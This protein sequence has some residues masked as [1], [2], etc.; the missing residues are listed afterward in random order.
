MMIDERD[1]ADVTPATDWLLGPVSREEFLRDHRG[2]RHLLLRRRSPGHYRELFSLARFDELLSGS[3]LHA[4]AVRVVRDGRADGGAA[5]LEDLYARYRDGSTLIMPSVHDRWPPLRELCRRLAGEF[6]AEC[7]V[8]AYLTPPRARGFDVHR[9]SHDVFVLQ[10][11]GSKRWRIHQDARQEFDLCEGDLLYLPRGLPHEAASAHGTSLHLSVG[12]HPLTWADVLLAGCEAAV[13]DD[14]AFQEPLPFGFART[15]GGRAATRERV[16]ELTARLGAVLTPDRLAD[17][18]VDMALL[19]EGDRLG[20]HL[21][22]LAGLAG[23]DAGTAVRRRPG[24]RW[25]TRRDAGTL[26]LPFHGKR[27]SLPA[28]HEAA[29]LRMADGEPFTAAGLPGE[30]GLA[31]VRRLVEEGFLTLAASG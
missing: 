2:R 6:S 22:D 18:A 14:P 7:R 31:L 25:E 5:G 19:A 8:N 17:D 10:V 12:V 29:F 27:L 30:D 28:R 15:T 24:L 13:A 3:G 11:A 23:L 26:V 9:D 4:G 16:R 20:G 1:G 21:L